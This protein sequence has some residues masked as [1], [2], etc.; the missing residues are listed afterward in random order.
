MLIEEVFLVGLCIAFIAFL[1]EYVDSTLGMG[2]GTTLTP[3][4]L[5][6][7]YEPMQVVPAVLLSNYLEISRS[8]LS[9]RAANL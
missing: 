9:V 7:G 6:M 8:C 2:Y 3:V 4:L 5:L 1:A